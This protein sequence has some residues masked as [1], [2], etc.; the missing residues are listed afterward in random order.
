MYD[1]FDSALL[2]SPIPGGR[3]WVVREP[4][5]YSTNIS[6]SKPGFDPRIVVAERFKTDFASIPRIFWF[7]LPRWGKYGNA[8]VVHDY[9]YWVKSTT[10]KEADQIMY[11]AMEDLKVGWLVRNAIYAAL[12]LG[13][14]TGWHRNTQDQQ[15]PGY[16]RLMKPEA[17]QTLVGEQSLTIELLESEGYQQRPPMRKRMFNQSDLDNDPDLSDIDPDDPL[18]NG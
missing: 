9:L 6:V 13:G 7:F 4:F 12:R 15:D 10:R 18:P 8:S 16:S 2:V 3:E 5:A 14:A 1:R 11:E 17:Y